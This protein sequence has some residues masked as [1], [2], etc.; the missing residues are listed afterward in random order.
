MERG[1]EPQ[2]KIGTIYFEYNESDFGLGDCETRGYECPSKVDKEKLSVV[3]IK[4]K[5]SGK[6]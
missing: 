2:G 3:I 4:E 1:V 6:F 5:F